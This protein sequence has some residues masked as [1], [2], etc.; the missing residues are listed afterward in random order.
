MNNFPEDKELIALVE[1]D[2]F[3]TPVTWVSQKT[4]HRKCYKLSLKNS[5]IIFN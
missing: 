2:L 1:Y 5:Q 4:D 3:L